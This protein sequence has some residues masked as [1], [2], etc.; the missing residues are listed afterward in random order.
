MNLPKLF[1]TVFITAAVALFS[2]NSMAQSVLDENE[3]TAKR[4][5]EIFEAAFM[6]PKI[7]EDG[8]ILVD[9][10]AVK[11]YVQVNEDKKIITFIS[12]FGLSEGAS[13]YDQ[14]K[15]FNKL[16]SDLI[17][18]RYQLMKGKLIVDY[19]MPYEGGLIP[20]AFM[21]SFNLFELVVRGTAI[22]DSDDLIK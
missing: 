14:L 10:G 20:H 13:E 1:A 19:Q 3:V 11:I 15:F 6:K 21:N 5:S 18:A 2:H 12:M 8:D 7:D 16:N 22:R 4:L 17:L 9:R